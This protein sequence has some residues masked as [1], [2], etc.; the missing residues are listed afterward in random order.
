MTLSNT[1]RKWIHRLFEAKPN[2][3]EKDLMQLLERLARTDLRLDVDTL[4]NMEINDI[5][6]NDCKAGEGHD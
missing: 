3:S 2:V 1:D 6:K 4:M 5:V